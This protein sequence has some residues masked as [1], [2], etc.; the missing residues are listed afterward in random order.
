MEELALVST[1]SLVKELMSRTTFA[2]IIICSPEEHRFE[3]QYHR[4]FMLYTP[5]NTEDTAMVLGNALSVIKGQQ[6]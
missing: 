3:N 1:E 5:M 2:G 6:N 4:D